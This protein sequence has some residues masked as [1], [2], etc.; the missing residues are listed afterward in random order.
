MK[1]GVI[2]VTALVTGGGIAGANVEV[3]GTAGLRVFNE[4][5]GFGVED[6]P[7]AESQKNTALFGVR[8]GAYF[9]P[10]LGAE[11]EVGGIP[12]EG[13]SMLFNVWNLTYRASFVAQ[14]AVS[15]KFAL[16]ALLGGGLHTILSSENTDLIGENT[17]VVPHAGLGV[18]YATGNGLGVRF[19]ARILLPPSS[20][21][22]SVTTDFEFLA[23]IYRDFG[24]RKPKKP[25]PPKKEPPKD[26]DPDKDGILGAADQC[27]N[28]AEDTDEF[29]DDDG[30]PDLDNDEDGVADTADKCATEPEDKDS[31][32]D[33]DGCPD[34]DNDGDGLADAADKCVNEPESAN[35]YL[36]EDG[37]PDDVP[38]ALQQILAAPLAIAFKANSADFAPPTKMVLDATAVTLTEAPHAKIDIV[39]HTDDQ[40]PPKGAKFADN[41]SLSQARAEA[42]KAYLLSKGVEAA[43]LTAVG[44]GDTEPLEAP[45][46]LKGGKLTAARAKNRRVELKL[47]IPPPPQ[48]AAQPAAPAEK[49]TE[50][51]KN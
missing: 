42:V 5:S 39:V 28:E 18:K 33:E 36:D 13:R 1:F 38:S 43:R 50:P 46:G 7:M 32:Q 49:A 2:V 47:V 44:R 10:M 26:E 23:S 17:K 21:S 30:C 6:S 19:D 35:G 40:A 8:L 14:R 3:G 4:N 29:K 9:G 25:E 51:E 16:F 12:G 31:F 27:A 24:Y 45:A 48:P 11:L 22:S 34:P 37:C 20:A 41:E 15:S